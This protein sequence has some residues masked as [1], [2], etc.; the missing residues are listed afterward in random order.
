[1]IRTDDLE[2]HSI[3]FDVLEGGS[4]SHDHTDTRG[5]STLITWSPGDGFRYQIMFVPLTPAQADRLGAPPNSYLVQDLTHGGRPLYV[6]YNALCHVTY[7]TGTAKIQRPRAI[8]F[9]AAINL[10]VG[11]REYG[12]ECYDELAAMYPERMQ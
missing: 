8:A 7:V 11:N 6:E 9:A 2:G 12:L 4:M 10:A 1:M 5:H 3:E